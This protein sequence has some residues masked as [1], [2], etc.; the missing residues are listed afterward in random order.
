MAHK[1]ARIVFHLITTKQAYDE[2]VFAQREI[3]HTQRTR[4]R[5]EQ[6]ARALGMQLVEKTTA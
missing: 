6:Q 2:T 5:L 3:E 1:L 4:K